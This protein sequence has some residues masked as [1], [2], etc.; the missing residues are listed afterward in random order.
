MEKN[1]V[2]EKISNGR[3]Y[4]NVCEFRVA[5]TGSESELITEGHACTFNIPYVLYDWGDYI[6]REQIDSHAFDECDMSDV[7][8][9]Y[10]HTGRVF[11]RT[12]NN[13]LTVSPDK[14]GLFTRADLSK[15]S[16]GPGMYQDIANGVIDRMSFGFVVAEDKREITENNETGVTEVLRTITKISKLYDVSAVSIP[17]NDGTDI[18]AR[19][20]CDGLIEEIKAERLEAEKRKNE[21]EK[22]Q[23]KIKMF[24]I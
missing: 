19:N 21:R 12:R 5:D 2:L 20:F 7:I 23:L 6:V 3:Q 14:V 10:D 17:A 24:N 11:A 16:G 15:S 8:M 22:L 13:T 18:S 1:N 9:Q 4:R